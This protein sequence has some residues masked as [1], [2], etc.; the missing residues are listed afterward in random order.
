LVVPARDHV[1]VAIVS[2]SEGGLYGLACG[3]SSTCQAG[4]RA[5]GDFCFVMT[6]RACWSLGQ[7]EILRFSGWL[8]LKDP[9][10]QTA[11]P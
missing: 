6:H 3:H 9:Q 7:T 1:L 11:W 2:L 5:R 4:R 8:G 10:A